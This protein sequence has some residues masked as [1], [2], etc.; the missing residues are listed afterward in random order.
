MKRRRRTSRSSRR[1]LELKKMPEQL[2]CAG[3]GNAAAHVWEEEPRR[4]SPSR[5]AKAR[6]DSSLPSMVYLATTIIA[7][8]EGKIR[9]RGKI[10]ISRY[11]LIRTQLQINYCIT[12]LSHYRF[13]PPPSAI[14]PSS[15]RRQN[16]VPSNLW[17]AIQ[18][19]FF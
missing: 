12:Y 13:L 1:G 7:S 5:Q 16:I 11:N 18:H 15:R 14:D 2:G 8:R 17:G 6:S 9:E 19:F 10:L 4:S 3:E